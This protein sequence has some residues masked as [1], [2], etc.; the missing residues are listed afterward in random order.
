VKSGTDDGSAVLSI[1]VLCIAA[2]CHPT[3]SM[4]PQESGAPVSVSKEAAP[5]PGPSSPRQMGWSD[6]TEDDVSLG[7]NL[8]GQLDRIDRLFKSTAFLHVTN[9]FASFWSESESR[10]GALRSLA[11]D[12]GRATDPRFY[13]ALAIAAQQRAHRNGPVLYKMLTK[14]ARPFIGRPWF[15]I[16][17]KILQ[18]QETDDGVTAGRVELEPGFDTAMFF[19]ARFPTP[20]IDGDRVDL[21]GF[22]AGDYTYK[23]RLGADVTVPSFA[24]AGMFKTGSIVAMNRIV[25]FW[26]GD[27]GAEQLRREPRKF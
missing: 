22:F 7:A 12:Q 23:N 13:M 8:R 9:D 1:V 24:V 3:G 19:A 4:E 17:A 2:S 14:N 26:K 16:N 11:S 18:I 20:F 21:I 5:G 27:I 10:T 6:Y 15:V 25:R